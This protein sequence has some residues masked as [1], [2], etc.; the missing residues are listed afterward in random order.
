MG[1]VASR[2][3]VKARSEREFTSIEDLK[4]RSG[5]SSTMIEILKSHGTLDGLGIS[6]QIDLF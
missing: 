6:D 2:G 3:I 1:T 5:A 4:K